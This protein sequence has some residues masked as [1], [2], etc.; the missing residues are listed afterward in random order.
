MLIGDPGRQAQDVVEM[1]IKALRTGAARTL[2]RAAGIAQDTLIAEEKATFRAASSFMTMS[3]GF[4]IETAKTSQTGMFS[5]FRAKEI[6][7]LRCRDA[8]SGSKNPAVHSRK[9]GSIWTA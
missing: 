1:Q 7:A 3:Q 4:R 2:T 9:R 5:V 8:P 6:R